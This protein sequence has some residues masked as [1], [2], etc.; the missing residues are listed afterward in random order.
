MF[1][2]DEIPSKLSQG[3]TASAAGTLIAENAKA[4]LKTAQLI[5]R[6]R[7]RRELLTEQQQFALKQA[8]DQVAGG[9]MEQE[10]WGVF[11]EQ[12]FQEAQQRHELQERNATHLQAVLQA[13]G[14]QEQNKKKQ[15]SV[16][17]D[18]VLGSVASGFTLGTS[19]LYQAIK[20]S[21]FS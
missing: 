4:M 5:R 19:F 21:F 13:R 6:E 3:I 20:Q 16:L 11:Q 15:K 8:E 2:I 10:Q 17:K 18:S 12:L 9:V 1:M 14:R 7:D